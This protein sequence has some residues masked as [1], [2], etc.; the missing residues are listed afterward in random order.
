MTEVVQADFLWLPSAAV[1]STC[2]LASVY[3][4]YDHILKTSIPSVADI[5]ISDAIYTAGAVTFLFCGLLYGR[6]RHPQSA[7]AYTGAWKD[8][9]GRQRLPWGFAPAYLLFAFI[10]SFA[11]PAAV[12]LWSFVQGCGMSSARLLLG[13]QLTFAVQ[14]LLETKLFHRN[15]MS[16]TVPFMFAMYRFW[17]LARSLWLLSLLNSNSWTSCVAYHPLFSHVI[18]ALLGFW[19]FD[20]GVTAVQLPW[21]YNWNLQQERS[22]MQVADK[23]LD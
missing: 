17:Q 21:V 16:P 2:A 23:K 10:V 9:A 22:M 12:M 7:P 18:Y 15:F 5:L 20:Y 6:Q 1:F 4:S 19:V 8:A 14:M 3:K 11:T 13:Y